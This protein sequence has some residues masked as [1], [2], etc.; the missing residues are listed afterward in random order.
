MNLNQI[1]SRI[2]NVFTTEKLYL[3]FT[4][5]KK[6]NIIKAI[7]IVKN[8][9]CFFKKT[10]NKNNINSNKVKSE[11]IGNQIYGVKSN[12]QNNNIYENIRMVNFPIIN[13]SND[14]INTLGFFASYGDTEG[15]KNLANIALLD[16]SDGIR[17]EQLLFDIFS[18]KKR[19]VSNIEDDIKNICFELYQN[20]ILSPQNKFC[21]PSKLLYMAG[22]GIQNSV[23]KDKVTTII[24]GKYL[25]QCEH[26]ETQDSDLWD[27]VRMLMSDEISLATQNI[28]EANINYPIGLI[29]PVSKDNLL[30]EIIKEQ[31]KKQNY[32]EKMELFPVNTGHHWILFALYK[33]DNEVKSLV[34]NSF[35]ELNY[36]SKL[37][38]FN[39]AKSAGVSEQN[40][41]FLE[42]NLQK[43]VPNGCGLF[44]IEAIKEIIKNQDKEPTH[45][46]AKFMSYFNG[47]SSE[48]QSE[49]NIFSR[50]Q[51]HEYLLN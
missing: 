34:F 42:K 8:T 30:K 47:L 22:S 40:I 37:A 39:S 15:I 46:L 28:Q 19:N 2:K 14:M 23:E 10:S 12:T 1:A 41:I 6:N 51:A 5:L 18:G 29:N 45:I 4:F 33:K 7:K 27:Q 31:T 38:L 32:L 17:A 24:L 50:R 44:V 43:N 49:F 35:H 48:Q 11:P 21:Y 13:N 36:E 16:N 3:D 9:N 20:S 25:S 26:E